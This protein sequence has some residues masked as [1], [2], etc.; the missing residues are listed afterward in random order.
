M[1][2]DTFL[3]ITITFVLYSLV[4][5]IKSNYFPVPAF[6]ILIGLIIGPLAFA[7]IVPSKATLWIAESTVV[8]MLFSAGL[9]IRW[10]NF[11]EAIKPG[12]QVGLMGIA[13]SFS[14]GT[15][16]V[17]L[18]TRRLDEALYVGAALSATSIGLSIPLLARHKLLN[19][20][21]GQI[22]LAAAVVDDVVALYLLSLLHASFTSDNGM[23]SIA[24]S[25]VSGM[26]SL[27][28]IVISV[29]LLNFYFI[30]RITETHKILRRI[31]TI[32]FVALSALTTHQFG[33]SAAVGAF[34]AGATMSFSICCVRSPDETFFENASSFLSPLFFLYIGLQITQLDMSSAHMVVLSTLVLIAAIAGKLLSP[35][36]LVNSTTA[37]ERNIIGWALVPRAEVAIVI[38][39]VGM[40]QGHLGQHSMISIVFMTMCTSMLAPVFMSIIV[41]KNK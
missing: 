9:E 40:Q 33:M 18:L 8:L 6:Y 14:L 39:S 13:I 22:L 29:S 3:F 11:L 35:W 37:N 1:V 20:K 30:K 10:H 7:W 12:I 32:F 25:L 15:L 28:F 19:S 2:T 17:V 24:L 36:V 26:L 16:V 31:L 21:A 23:L 41:Q 38:A 27:V 5:N 34:A 4:R